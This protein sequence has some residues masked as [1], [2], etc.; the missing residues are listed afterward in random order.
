M[1][2]EANSA[3]LLLDE[4]PD[5]D[6]AAVNARLERELGETGAALV[7]RTCAYHFDGE[8]R[9]GEVA[10]LYIRHRIYLLRALER[11][12]TVERRR[13]AA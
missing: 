5:L 12:A 3:L 8:E 10:R 13:A 4:F 11:Q 9:W 7:W 6:L 2:S 1:V